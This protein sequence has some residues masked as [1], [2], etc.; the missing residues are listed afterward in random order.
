MELESWTAI[1]PEYQRHHLRDDAL[2]SRKSQAFY[3]NAPDGP[4][5]ESVEANLRYDREQLH[6]KLGYAF[7]D[8]T[9]KRPS[10]ST[11]TVRRRMPTAMNKYCR[12]TAFS[13]IPRH[14]GNF[15]LDYGVRRA[16][17]GWSRH[18]SKRNV[19]Q[20][21]RQGQSDPAPGRIYGSRPERRI[22]AR[23]A[24]HALHGGQQCDR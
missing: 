7:T 13:G 1:T 23:R 20:F 11:R 2:Q 18:Q 12:E 15:V 16:H 24:C 9:F 4:C 21:R 3:T 22:P 8:A 10:C 19:Y 5:A 17:R 14:R 6:L